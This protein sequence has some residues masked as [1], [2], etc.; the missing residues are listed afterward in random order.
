MRDEP[1]YILRRHLVAQRDS[2]V[3]TRDL[4]DRRQ[5]RKLVG[6]ALV[7]R[8][9]DALQMGAEEP[10]VA[11][12]RPGEAVLRCDLS[13]CGGAVRHGPGPAEG[14]PGPIGDEPPSQAAGSAG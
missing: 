14:G 1:F 10:G 2:V 11:T 4:G 8:G 3:V 12:P 9:V 13:A 6:D 5:V 7:D